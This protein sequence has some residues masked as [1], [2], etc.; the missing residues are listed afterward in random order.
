MKMTSKYTTI[1]GQFVHEA[2]GDL[3]HFFV[4][5]PAGSVVATTDREGRI[6]D[7][8]S[9]WPGGEPQ[10]YADS[11]KAPEFTWGWDQPDQGRMQ[12]DADM[13]LMRGIYQPAP[14]APWAAGEPLS[15]SNGEDPELWQ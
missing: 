11:S 1:D 9:C 15:S 8:W 3:S 6:I 4:L 12:F 5:D 13:K 7:Q 2:R 10:V 14:L